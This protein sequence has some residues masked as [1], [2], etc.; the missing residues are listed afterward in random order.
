MLPDEMS[1]SDPNETFGTTR[2]LIFLEPEARQS[3]VRCPREQAP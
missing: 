1:E 3:T 2:A